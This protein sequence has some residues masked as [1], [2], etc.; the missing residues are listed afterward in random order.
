MNEVSNL[1]P[2]VDDLQKD[3]CCSVM[4][5]TKWGHGMA[6]GEREAT[7]LGANLAELSPVQSEPIRFALPLP[8]ALFNLVKWGGA[9]QGVPI[10]QILL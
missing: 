4:E 1:L 2:V 7:G 3:G 9:Q 5:I 8:S 6:E 10:M